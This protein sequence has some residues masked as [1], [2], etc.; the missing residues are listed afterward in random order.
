MGAR[1][2]IALNTSLS[3][4]PASAQLLCVSYQDFWCLVSP[5][6]GKGLL[7]IGHCECA[8]LSV[9]SGWTHRL[10]PNLDHEQLNVLFSIIA[11]SMYPPRLIKD[12][13]T[14]DHP[15]FDIVCGHEGSPLHHKV[16]LFIQ[17]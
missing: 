3:S 16:H 2:R 12:K 11:E 4:R 15:L 1:N 14:G 5:A 6:T 10:K 17:P 8:H 9:L 13:V 7:V